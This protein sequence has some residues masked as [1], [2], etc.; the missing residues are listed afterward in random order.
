VKIDGKLIGRSTDVAGFYAAVS[1][2]GFDFDGKIVMIV[3]AGGAARAIAYEAAKC[4]AAK[5]FIL[6]RNMRKSANL[7]DE[8]QKKIQNCEFRPL[9]LNK[10]N[11]NE[12]AKCANIFVN[13]TPIG[14]CGA[15][16]KSLEFLKLL[17][18]GAA[19][20]DLLYDPPETLLIQEA[21][22][23]G[24]FAQNGLAMLIWQAIFAQEIFL[25]QKFPNK[26]KIFNEIFD[27]I[28]RKR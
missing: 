20:F 18:K 25:N 10:K 3:G 12:T 21:K 1:R 19:V 28:S 14:R 9:E 8:L 4:G 27:E 16:F 22:K 6:A 17:P 5:I 7:C 15:E 2:A 26:E 11:L 23:L 24:I 13:C